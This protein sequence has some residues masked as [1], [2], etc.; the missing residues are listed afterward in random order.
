MPRLQGT[1]SP[2]PVC[3]NGHCSG[4]CETE[5]MRVMDP[6]E[7]APDSIQRRDGARHPRQQ[8]DADPSRAQVQPLDIVPMLE[9]KAGVEWGRSHAARTGAGHGLPLQVREA[10]RPS[11]GARNMVLRSWCPIGGKCSTPDDFVRYRADN[12]PGEQVITDVR[13]WHPSI[14]MPRVYSRILLEIVAV[15]VERLNDISKA[16]AM[17]EGQSQF[18]FLLMADRAR[19]LKASANCG[20]TS[21][22]MVP[23]Q[24]TPGM[25]WLNSGAFLDSAPAQCRQCRSSRAGIFSSVPLHPASGRDAG[26]AS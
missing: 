10:R 24:Q 9:D 2:S 21:T 13:S 20:S 8:E 16:D 17:T 26:A 5:G 15:R 11:V 25:G 1:T 18:W 12:G 22:A 6:S 4:K 3:H 23:G 14:H 19:T 7:R